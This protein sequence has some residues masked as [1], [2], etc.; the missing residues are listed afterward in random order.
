MEG[1]AATHAGARASARGRW[2]GWRDTRRARKDG[3]SG[4]SCDTRRSEGGRGGFPPIAHARTPVADG[5]AENRRNRTEKQQPGEPA[6]AS[7]NCVRVCTR[8]LA[9]RR[10]RG[11]PAPRETAARR[12][13]ARVKVNKEIVTTVLSALTSCSV[14]ACVHVF[15]CV[16]NVGC[17]ELGQQRHRD[18]VQA[19]GGR[20]PVVARVVRVAQAGDKTRK[21]S[22]RCLRESQREETTVRH[23]SHAQ[24]VDYAE[25]RARTRPSPS[26]T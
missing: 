18:R 10:Q 21:P 16:S 8:T 26:W 12:N 5:S 2:H 9:R 24:A 19:R 23:R 7:T 20:D 25:R 4:C 15:L 22:P 14:F 11:E 17:S 1:N 6:R 13:R 3:R